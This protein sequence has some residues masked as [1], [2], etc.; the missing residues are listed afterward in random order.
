ML[1]FET[2]S[3]APLETNC[4]LVADVEAGAALLV[5]APWQIVDRILHLRE[6]LRVAV[7]LIVCTHGHWDHTMGLAELQA[8]TGA[9]VACHPLD[10]HMLEQP[11]FEPFS[12]PFELTPVTP[13]RLLH[14]GDE[15]TLGSHRLRVLHTPG[16]TPG[17]ICLYDA[18][19]AVLFSGDTLFAGTCGRM[20]LPGGDP[21]QM[22]HSLHRL[23]TLPPAT[24]VYPGHGGT[25]TISREGWL[26]EAETVL[27]W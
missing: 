8:A 1:T 21:E 24:T 14:E 26:A 16:H 11:S 3:G 6:R 22:V 23:H 25:T 5:D 20:D 27:G 2:I 18:E 15:I 13:D 4:Y 12:F 9:Q 7:E 19:A 10:A 17:C